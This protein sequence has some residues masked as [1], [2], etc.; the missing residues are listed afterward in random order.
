MA[1]QE[2]DR[3]DLLREATG[4]VDRVEIVADF[5]G[6]PIVIGF[7]RNSAVSLF[8]GQAEVYQFNAD[9]HLRRGYLS[10]QLLKA[11]RGR[12]VALTRERSVDKTVLAR[13][14]YDNHQSAAL[15]RRLRHR[16]DELTDALRDS[17]F[18]LQGVVSSTGRD[19]IGRITEWLEGMPERIL[20]ASNPRAG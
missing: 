11:E 2:D 17:R 5:C 4:L 18:E 15:L 12:L 13:H 14:P 9:G 19:V 3:E 8:F 6:E 7:R 20:I 16:L 10:G 1:R